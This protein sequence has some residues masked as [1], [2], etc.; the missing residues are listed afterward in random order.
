MILISLYFALF[1]GMRKII[2][3]LRAC[4]VSNESMLY[5]FMG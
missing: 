4:Q 2:L 3:K 1:I 5:S